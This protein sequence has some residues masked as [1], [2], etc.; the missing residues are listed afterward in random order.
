MQYDIQHRKQRGLKLCRNPEEPRHCLTFVLSL[1]PRAKL[2]C[3]FQLHAL[4]IHRFVR[5][6]YY[7]VFR[8]M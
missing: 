7:T 3:A 4:G 2:V 6:I 1:L 8:S 5:Q